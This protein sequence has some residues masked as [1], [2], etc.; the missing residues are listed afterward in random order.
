MV[1]LNNTERIG[2]HLFDIR[3]IGGANPFNL[4]ERTCSKLSVHD[5]LA[6]N[7]SKISRE[8]ETRMMEQFGEWLCSSA[9]AYRTPYDLVSDQ[10]PVHKDFSL[11]RART[12]HLTTGRPG[13]KPSSSQ[14]L[15]KCYKCQLEHRLDSCESFKTLSNEERIYFVKQHRFCSCVTLI[16]CSCRRSKVC[17]VDDCCGR[18]HPL[19]HEDSPANSFVIETHTSS[20]ACA[21]STLTQ[22]IA[23]DVIKVYIRDQSNSLVAANLLFDEGSDRSFVRIG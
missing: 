1:I 4:I 14:T 13:M 12:N 16:A 3:R 2:T 17:G 18:H 19:I 21:Q 6:K 7:D 15:Q 20:T 11:Q 5:R 9:A 8:E 10:H 22:K 23:L